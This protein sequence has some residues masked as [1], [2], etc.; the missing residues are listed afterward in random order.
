MLYLTKL[1]QQLLLEILNKKNIT[2]KEQKTFLCKFYNSISKLQKMELI[3]SK[4]IKNNK[5]KIYYLTDLG[6]VFT[7]LLLENKIYYICGL[8][9]H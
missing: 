2:K 6:I 3:K 5:E 1:D 8:V 7:N 9:F 4:L